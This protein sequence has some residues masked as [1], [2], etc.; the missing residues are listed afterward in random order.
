[1]QT[2]NKL[3]MTKKGHS[4]SIFD[5]WGF[6]NFMLNIF[7]PFKIIRSYMLRPALKVFLYYY[8]MYKIKTQAG[9]I[10]TQNIFLKLFSILLCLFLIVCAAVSFYALFYFSK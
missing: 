2:D 5:V 7:D 6:L 9:I 3:K 10:N 8:E 1:M 4:S